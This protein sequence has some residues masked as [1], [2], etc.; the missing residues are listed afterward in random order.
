MVINTDTIIDSVSKFEQTRKVPCFFRE[1][2][3]GVVLTAPANSFLSRMF[4]GKIRSDLCTLSKNYNASEVAEIK[5][6][7]FDNFFMFMKRTTLLIALTYMSKAAKDF[8]VFKK[9][10]DYYQMP[11]VIYTRRSLEPVRRNSLLERINTLA[12]A[13]L[14][15]EM[16]NRIEKGMVKSISKKMH[17]YETL[18]DFVFDHTKIEN[19]QLENY[20]RIFTYH[21]LLLFGLLLT[22]VA[23]KCYS[24]LIT[25]LNLAHSYGRRR[26]RKRSSKAKE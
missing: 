26:R 9:R 12:E 17:V 5:R 10:R 15:E 25:W 18:D 2:D 21:A 3:I 4:T 23:I 8:L 13:G 24:T 7:G 22:F 6:R 14:F 20:R 11:Y 16:Y 1:E 19:V